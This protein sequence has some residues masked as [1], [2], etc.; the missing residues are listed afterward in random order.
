MSRDNKNRKSI[1]LNVILQSHFHT[2]YSLSCHNPTPVLVC[3]GKHTPNVEGGGG[4]IH[5]SI[6]TLTPMW[7]YYGYLELL[8]LFFCPTGVGGGGG[9]VVVSI[10]KCIINVHCTCESFMLW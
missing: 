3:A 4:L 8:L 5:L 7:G 2:K 1:E 9:G 10:D 6:E